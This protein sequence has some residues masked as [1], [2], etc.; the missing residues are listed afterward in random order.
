MVDA[1]PRAADIGEHR[2][3]VGA[4]VGADRD[5]FRS[6]GALH[7]VAFRHFQRDTARDHWHGLGRRR[8]AEI[9]SRPGAPAFGVDQVLGGDRTGHGFA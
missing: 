6:A 1:G 2:G 5:L 8:I 3:A 7:H 4:L 9:G